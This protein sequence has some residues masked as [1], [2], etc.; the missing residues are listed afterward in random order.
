MESATRTVGF[1][2]VV[3]DDCREQLPV[4][5]ALR[6]SVSRTPHGVL[7]SAPCQ[8][9]SLWCRTRAQTSGDGTVVLVQ[10]CDLKRRPT[11]PV[12]PV[13]PLR[14]RADL[15]ALT[16]WMTSTPL[17][18]DTLPARLRTRTPATHA[19]NN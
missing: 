18:A 2:A 6:E 17:S 13:G 1:T 8:L 11:G 15:A 14:D 4:L 19:Q 9:G 12:I 5:D 7:V 3:C 10:P 16:G